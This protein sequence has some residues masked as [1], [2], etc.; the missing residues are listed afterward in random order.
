MSE[1][2][3]ALRRRA[4]TVGLLR[5]LLSLDGRLRRRGWWLSWLGFVVLFASVQYLAL[6]FLSFGHGFTTRAEG[7]AL[8]A[9]VGLA[10]ELVLLWP[11]TAVMVRR[12]HDRGYGA[13]RTG[14]V[15]AV[16]ILLGLA[17]PLAPQTPRLLLQVALLVY[18]VADYG[19]TPGQRGA[20][21]YG[22]DPRLAPGAP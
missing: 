6:A 15:W 8:I 19:F 10:L 13:A 14:A 7:A 22:P 16:L 20:N 18:L 11:A 12:G 1:R 5:D 4:Q 2:P 21:A 17:A 9:P 3:P